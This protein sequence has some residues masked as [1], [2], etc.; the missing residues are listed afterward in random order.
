MAKFTVTGDQYFD[1]DGQM[2][3]IKRQFR[4]KGGSPIDP[5]LVTLALQNIIEGK[6]NRSKKKNAVLKLLSKGESIIIDACDGTETLVM[7]K[8]TFKSGI[9]S[10]FKRWDT[11]KAGVSTEKTP[12]QV[13]EMVKDATLAQ[14]FGSLGTDLDKLCLTQH[15]IKTFCEVHKEWL[16]KDEY[17]TFF[18]FK[19]DKQFFVA[20]VSVRSVGLYVGMNRFKYDFVCSAEYSRRVVVPELTA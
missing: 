13:H 18:L 11:N 4:Q 5:E 2:I 12:V 14:M 8:E 17:A 6:F 20:G 1:I 19:V 9:D 16:R 10:D 3:E 15:Q 7:A